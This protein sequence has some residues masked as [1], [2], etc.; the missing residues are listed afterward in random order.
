MHIPKKDA[1]PNRLQDV[2]D[3]LLIEMA[4][5]DSDDEEFATKLDQLAKL[6]KM[7]ESNNSRRVSPDTMALIGANLLGIA[8]IIGYERANVIASKAMS[9]VTKLR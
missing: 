1:K 8:M 7:K 4:E 6:Y 9:F 5:M 2:I 3:K